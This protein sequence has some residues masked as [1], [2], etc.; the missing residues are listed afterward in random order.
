MI[1]REP[2]VRRPE[3]DT[4]DKRRQN[5]TDDH[6]PH[7]WLLSRTYGEDEEDGGASQPRIDRLGACCNI[8]RDRRRHAQLLGSLSSTINMAR[9]R[10]IAGRLKSAR[11]PT[12]RTVLRRL[13]GFWRQCQRERRWRRSDIR[14]GRA[15]HRSHAVPTDRPPGMVRLLGLR[16]PDVTRIA[17]AD[18][19][20][21]AP[22]LGVVLY[23]IPRAG[24]G[25]IGAK[26]VAARTIRWT[27][28]GASIS[29]RPRGH[30]RLG[31]IAPTRK[32]IRR[33]VPARPTIP[34]RR[35]ES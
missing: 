15:C 28:S 35:L 23:R 27:S 14:R 18:A 26:L 33:R 21:R 11:R 2:P 24:V 17:G 6:A 32:G 34:R 22:Y 5:G 10:D 8:L 7:L 9:G 16:E 30:A 4:T 19:R 12:S 20:I 25:E 29:L 3:A 1:H 13:V 31:E